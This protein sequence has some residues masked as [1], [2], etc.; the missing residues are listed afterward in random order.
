[1]STQTGGARGVERP[2]WREPELALVLVLACAAYLPRLGELPARGEEPRRAQVAYELVCWND[3]LVPREQGEPFLSRP[4]L[5]N[6]LIAATCLAVGSW[7]EWAIRLPSALATVL[8]TLLIYGYARAGL[9]RLGALAAALAFATLGEMFS[10]GRQAETEAV[11]ILFLGGALLAWHWAWLRGRPALAWLAGYALMALA[12]LTKGGPQPP[13]YFVGSVTLYLVVTGQWRR[14]FSRAHLAGVLTG[15]ALVGAWAVPYYLDQG[16]DNLHAL[17]MGDTAT[18]FQ[19]W[20]VSEV[21]LHLAGYPLEVLGCTAPWSLLLLA[22]LS[23]E[24]R[25]SLGG[26]RPQAVFAAVCLGLAFPSC[27]LP[28]GGQTRYLTPLFPCLAVLVGVV[29][30]RCGEAAAASALRAGWRWYLR[31]AAA[32]AAG[33]AAF[34][35]AV[36]WLSHPWLAGWAAPPGRAA[37][38][39]LACLALAGLIVWAGR[40][41]GPWRARLAVVG[42]ASYMVLLFGGVIADVRLRKTENTGG[43][44]RRLKEQLPPGVGL[45]SLGHIDAIFAYYYGAPIPVLPKPEDGPGPGPGEYFCVDGLGNTPLKLPFSWEK[46]AALSMDRNRHERPDRLVVVGRR[47]P[48]GSPPPTQEVSRAPWP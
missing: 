25:R 30:Q 42:V 26:A 13:V 9:S 6:W 23:A 11:F 32:A 44:V 38:Y 19:D 40:A 46:V 18:R 17:W 39:A 21:L 22:Y 12:A 37:S 5:Q 1:M 8:V 3:W 47:L 20:K 33:T 24:F 15:A 2:W 43:A 41:A 34:L 48:P 10:T 14:L 36:P 7:E 27:W 35:P 4:P 45:V 29:V 31:V 16:W 28:P